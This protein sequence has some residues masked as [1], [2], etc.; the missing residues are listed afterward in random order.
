MA[1]KHKAYIAG[2]ITDD[3]D[4][5]AKFAGAEAYLKRKGFVVMSPAI[6]PDGF[7]YEDYMHIC[8]AMMWVCR[9]GICFMLPDWK[10]SPGAI[11]EHA[12]AKETGMEIHYLTTDELKFD[13]K[14]PTPPRA[15]TIREGMF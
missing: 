11:R 9:Q 6:M 8:F 14:P 5:R 13:R 2:K 15:R 10:D 1:I 4:Y 3:P 12:N 7:E